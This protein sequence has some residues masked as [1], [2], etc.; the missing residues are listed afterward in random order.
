MPLS[1]YWLLGVFVA[2]LGIPCDASSNG[3]YG[4]HPHYL[5]RAREGRV[6]HHQGWQSHRRAPHRLTS[7]LHPRWP[8]GTPWMPPASLGDHKTHAA[9]FV[10]APRQPDTSGRPQVSSHPSMNRRRLS[11]AADTRSRSPASSSGV[12][13]LH[14]ARRGRRR[15]RQQWTWPRRLITASGTTRSRPRT[16]GRRQNCRNGKVWR[17]GTC[18][19][20]YL[21]TWDAEG[22]ECKCIYGTYRHASGYCHNY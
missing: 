11:P 22:N 5:P 21:S 1:R 4:T 10:T 17:G 9:L 12:S 14:R 20:P 7:Q 2:L 19:C 16:T 13:Q 6:S 3:H 8:Q 18:V 15:G